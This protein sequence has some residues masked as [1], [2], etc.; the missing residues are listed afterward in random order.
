MVDSKLAADE[1]EESDPYV[2]AAKAAA[3]ERLKLPPH[4]RGNAVIG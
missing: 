3:A 2:L 1:V 4:M